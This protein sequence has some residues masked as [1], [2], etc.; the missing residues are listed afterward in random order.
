M[1]YLANIAAITVLLVGLAWFGHVTARNAKLSQYVARCIAAWLVAASL[2][3][4]L[5]F[6]PASVL[7]RTLN[8]VST[9]ATLAVACLP[10]FALLGSILYCWGGRWSRESSLIWGF[11]VAALTVPL[12]PMFLL[13]STCVIQDN[14][15]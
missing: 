9:L 10:F 5:H 13:V 8:P 1:P 7:P 14:C 3:F 2:L 11:A 15:L 12:A 6:T 4:L